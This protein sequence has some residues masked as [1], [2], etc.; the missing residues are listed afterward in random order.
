MFGT[1]LLS[2]MK[3]KRLSPQ[4]Q[5]F[6]VSKVPQVT[7]PSLVKPLESW[8]VAQYKSSIHWQFILCYRQRI[9][10]SEIQN[11]PL[12]LLAY[13]IYHKIHTEYQFWAS[14]LLSWHGL[15][16]TW[17]KWWNYTSS[18]TWFGSIWLPGGGETHQHPFLQ[19][20]T[21]HAG[22]LLCVIIHHDLNTTIHHLPYYCG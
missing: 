2:G 12:L 9:I 1:I 8:A 18:R 6:K 3:R 19:Q 15:V 4:E 11:F 16:A 14:I 5:E 22:F 17:F 7:L 13:Y 21:Q 10:Y 20:S